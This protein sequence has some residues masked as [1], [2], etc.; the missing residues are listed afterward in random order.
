MLGRYLLTLLTLISM[1]SFAPFANAKE[2]A[3]ESV[4]TMPTRTYADWKAACMKLP[5]NR[6]SRGRFPQRSLLPLARFQ[7]LPGAERHAGPAQIAHAPPI[8]V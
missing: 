1:A 8:H 5:S 6:A 2:P 7:E 3:V 4:A